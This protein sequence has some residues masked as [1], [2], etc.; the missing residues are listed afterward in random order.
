M[1]E[2]RRRS[3]LLELG[4]GIRLD[5]GEMHGSGWI[6][7]EMHAPGTGRLRT[8]ILASWADYLAGRLAVEVMTPR[9]PVTLD[10]D[11]HL[12]R[13]APGSG[14]VTGVCRVV[15]SGRSVFV[16]GIEFADESGEPIGTAT[17]S[18][19]VV[20]DPA[21]V[22]PPIPSAAAGLPPGEPLAVPFAERAGCA[23]RGPGV[24]VL[25][26]SE[27]GINASGTVGGGLIALAV[28]EAFLSLEP[29]RTLSSLALRYLQ[30]VRIGP[31]TATAHVRHGLG[32]AELRDSGRDDRLCVTAT[33]RTFAGVP[34]AAG[35]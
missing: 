15:K 1:G 2:E 10:L 30:P 12:Y 26:R 9:V 3:I 7:P 14:T 20:P 13:P 22:M 11:V 5:G 24:A 19:M 33:A 4:F 27:E 18:F 25:Q 35:S 29:G 34:A 8:S 16:A 17:G 21:I 31:A 6:T 23:R 28:E 32:H